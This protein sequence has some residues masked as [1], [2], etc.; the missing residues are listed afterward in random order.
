M[1]YCSEKIILN[2]ILTT[3]TKKVYKNNYV[4]FVFISHVAPTIL[5]QSNCSWRYKHHDHHLPH[6]SL[7]LIFIWSEFDCI[8]IFSFLVR[9][10][11]FT[12]CI[13]NF[14]IINCI[15]DYTW[16]DWGWK[17]SWSVLKPNIKFYYSNICNYC[18]R[19]IYFYSTQFIEYVAPKVPEQKKCFTNVIN[20]GLISSWS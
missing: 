18:I 16:C 12:L 6:L 14:L 1:Q 5:T 11:K 8:Y 15:M 2:A 10:R 3:I 7:R 9:P 20:S 4:C 13:C 19:R 17:K